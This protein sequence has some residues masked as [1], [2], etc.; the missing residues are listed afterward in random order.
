MG[1]QCVDRLTV[2]DGVAVATGWSDGSMPKIVI[3][4]MPSLENQI[5]IRYPRPDVNQALGLSGTKLGFRVTA[6]L[7]SSHADNSLLAVKFED[8][9]ILRV[10]STPVASGIEVLTTYFNSQVSAANDPRLIEIGSRAR[11]GNYYKDRFPNLKEYLGIDVKEGPNVDLVVD[12][13]VMSSRIDTQYDFAFSVSVFEHLIMPWVATFELNKVLKVGGLA[14]IQSHPSWPL[15]EEPW[16]FFR[17]SKDS[18]K[19]LF[20]RLTG[21]EIVDVGYGIGATVV[22]VQCNNGALQGIDTEQ[23][24]LLS[25]C[26]ARKISEPQVDWSADPAAIF[27]LQYNHE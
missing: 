20:N 1:K 9:S 14:Y 13:H 10:Q 12:A 22:P 18:W 16:D 4:G 26:I 15:H 6:I 8:G 21:F 5:G 17:F 23:T 19:G 27:D 2:I 24:Y 3:N 11:S 25:A 7:D